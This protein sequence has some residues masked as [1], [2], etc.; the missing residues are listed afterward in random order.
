MWSNLVTH[1]RRG[2]QLAG[3]FLVFLGV[4]ALALPSFGRMDQRGVSILDLEL[5][6]TSADAAEQ[7]ARLG[8]AGVDAAQMSIYLDF[9]YLVL[10]GVVFSAACALL[11]ARAADRGLATMAGVGRLVAWA[12]VIAAALDAIENVALLRVLGGQ[13]DQPWPGIAFGFATVKFALLA[14]VIVY[15]L[16]AFLATLRKRE[17]AATTD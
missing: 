3:L 13:V 5:M 7:V 12:A 11:A 15:L 8:P 1:P 10:Y 16:V 9:P 14:M 4:G 17:P 6:R 2:S